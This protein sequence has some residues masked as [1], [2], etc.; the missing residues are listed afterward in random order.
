MQFVTVNVT[1]IQRCKRQLFDEGSA[2]RVM[3]NMTVSHFLNV[4]LYDTNYLKVIINRFSVRQ[5][6]TFCPV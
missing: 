5:K 4:L 2:K 1:I 3:T 6:Q